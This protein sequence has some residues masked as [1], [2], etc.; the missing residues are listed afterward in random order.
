MKLH[1]L[2]LASIVS[3]TISLSPASGIEVPLL[4][5]AYVDSSSSGTPVPSNTNYGK[6]GTLRVYSSGGRVMRTYIK[7]DVS[8]EAIPST[9]TPE[10]LSQATLRLWINDAG[11][12]LGS[13][14]IARLTAAFGETALK[15]SNAS[16]SPWDP[17]SE[18]TVPNTGLAEGEY[19]DIDI[20]AWVKAWMSGTPNHGLVL[21]PFSG[22]T[23]D[24]RFD[25][26]ESLDTAHGA[27]LDLLFL[28]SARVPA[29]GDVSMGSFTQ[30]PTP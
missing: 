30:G 26:K 20:T 16:S 13:F 9:V 27:K 1:S 7:F 22:S 6:S 29:R 25:S 18:T 11:G 12:T 2:I 24:M 8:T 15:Y 14:K 5:D 3:S 28:N 21:L 19:L 10:Q 23:V 17:A 4:D